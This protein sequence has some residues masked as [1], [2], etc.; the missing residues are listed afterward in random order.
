MA[1]LRESVAHALFEST[2][3]SGRPVQIHEIVAM[4]EQYE[5]ASARA[6]S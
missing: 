2:Q 3:N 1:E 5:S 4:I 6:V